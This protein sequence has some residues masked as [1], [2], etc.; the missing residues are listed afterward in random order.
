MRA[1]SAAPSLMRASPNPTFTVH[2]SPLPPMPLSA[3]TLQMSPRLGAGPVA[4][5]KAW[6]VPPC[7][8]A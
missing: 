5:L 2:W 6:Y 4:V 3:R 8:A 7:F 1:S